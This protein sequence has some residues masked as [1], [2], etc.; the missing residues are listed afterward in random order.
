MKLDKDFSFWTSS[1]SRAIL[2][3]DKKQG[4]KTT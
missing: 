3:Y 4:M 1:G 2:M